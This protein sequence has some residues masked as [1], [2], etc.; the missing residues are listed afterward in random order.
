M[1]F[2]LSKDKIGAD[3][4]ALLDAKELELV[5]ELSARDD[6]MSLT[7]SDEKGVIGYAV[8]GIDNDNMVTVYAARSMNS[9]IAKA[10]MIGVFGAAQVMGMPLRV[11]TE[12]L[13]GMARMMGAEQAFK[14]LD[15][16]GVPMGVFNGQQV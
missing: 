8:F 14:C 16:D 1:K 12:K 5:A 11:H 15:L 10:A 3:V 9:F 4:L 2:A 7:I 13:R 6:T